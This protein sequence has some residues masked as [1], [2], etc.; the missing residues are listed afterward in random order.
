MYIYLIHW[1]KN[2]H[3]TKSAF[4]PYHLLDAINEVKPDVNYLTGSGLGGS[5]I[6]F[7]DIAKALGSEQKLLVLDIIKPTIDH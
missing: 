4:G 1:K 2:I 5:A 3:Y 6:R 7:A